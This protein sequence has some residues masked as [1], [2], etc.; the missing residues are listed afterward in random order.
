MASELWQRL[1]A[2][3][4][5]ADLRQEDV[6]RVTGVS[7]S[8]VAQWEAEE[9]E[10]RTTPSIDQ[11]KAVAKLAKLP[12]EWM[13]NDHANVDDVWQIG[14]LQMTT[15]SVPAAADRLAG[16]F[17]GAIEFAVMQRKTELA[18]GFRRQIPLLVDTFSPDFWW[19]KTLVCFRVDQS[20]L[21][22][23]CGKLLM[24]E[25]AVGGKVRKVIL[26]F[27]GDRDLALWDS[28]RNTFDIEIVAV[29]S[30]DGAAD[31]LVRLA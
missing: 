28:L 7:R 15:P 18:A 19:G 1:R 5:Y 31:F 30:P 8:A 11:V 12:L 21:M 9:P 10:K 22:D 6:R 13:L 29:D 3:R 23:I 4:R 20:P 24:A 14:G 2:A 25:K 17:A 16:A 26:A 27:G